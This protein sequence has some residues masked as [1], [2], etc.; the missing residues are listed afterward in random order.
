MA[1]GEVP[2]TGDPGL[3]VAREMERCL[4]GVLTDAEQLAAQHRL[5]VGSA[6]TTLDRVELRTTP[7][8]GA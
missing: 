4:V 8:I 5:Q 3:A 6:L 1:L 7:D 2:G